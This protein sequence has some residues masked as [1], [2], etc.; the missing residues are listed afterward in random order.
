MYVLIA[1]NH[2]IRLARTDDLIF[3]NDGDNLIDGKGGDD[4][5]F[6]GSGM[7]LSLVVRVTMSFLAVMGRIFCW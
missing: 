3:G 2:L 6:G 5:I 1:D 4:I 7:T